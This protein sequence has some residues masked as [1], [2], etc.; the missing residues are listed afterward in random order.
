MGAFRDKI[1]I[2]TGGA[3]GIGRAVG[4]AMAQ[5]GATVVLADIEVDLAQEAAKAIRGSGGRAE[6]A[7]LDVT[8]AVAVAALVESTAKKHGR[9]DFMFNNAGIA[10]AGET[11]HRS[12]QDWYRTLDVNL[13]GVIHGVDAAYRLMLRQG[14]GHIVNTASVAGLIPVV[15]EID[16]VAAKHAVVGLSTTLRAEAADFGVKVSV[17]CPGFVETPILDRNMGYAHDFKYRFESVDQLKNFFKVRFMPAPKAAVQI[18]DGVKRNKAI[19]VVTTHAKVF[20]LVQRL[21][22]AWMV[23]LQRK[24]IQI[25]RKKYLSTVEG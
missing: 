16:Y 8:D 13:R 21:S 23:A 18:L 19:I 11:R 5:R 22:P 10:I 17:L 12:I 24:S 15:N 4:E 7:E 9:L 3:S 25:F 2:I 6:A 20:W 1:A 14:Y